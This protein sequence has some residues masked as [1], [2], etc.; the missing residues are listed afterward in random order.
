M[1]K[2]N[3]DRAFSPAATRQWNTLPDNI[4]NVQSESVFK[5]KIKIYHFKE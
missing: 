4:S 1:S 5:R 3:G 2:V